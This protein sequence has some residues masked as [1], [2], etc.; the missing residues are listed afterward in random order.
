MGFQDLLLPKPQIYE[1]HAYV[2]HA[3]GSSSHANPYIFMH[4]VVQH[5]FLFNLKN[6]HF[7]DGEFYF[8]SRHFYDEQF[9]CGH[10]TAF[11]TSGVK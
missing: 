6:R 2:G 5:T 7:F 1:V 4:D 8:N 3:E 9:Y 11:Y 10:F